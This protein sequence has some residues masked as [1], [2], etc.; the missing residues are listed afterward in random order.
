M[1][2]DSLKALNAVEIL[3]S[4]QVIVSSLEMLKIH[5]ALN[6]YGWLSWRV[7]RLSHPVFA[8]L[9]KKLRFDVLLKYPNVLGLIVFKILGGAF[10]IVLIFLNMSTLIPLLIIVTINLLMI[11]RNAQSNDGSDQMASIILIALSLA[12]IVN[13][14]FSRSATLVF[15]AAQ[16]SLAYGTSGFLKLPKIG[17]HDGSYATDIL[18]TSSFGNKKLL[19][20]FQKNRFIATTLGRA[21]VFGDCCIAFAFLMPPSISI[22]L[23]V[24][25]I[26]L[27]LGI[28][29]VMGL[30]TFLWSFVATYPAI[31]WVSVLINK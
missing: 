28:G 20:L 18:K 9:S 25:G 4:I 15:I 8:T 27:H 14:N 21:V 22:G 17:W 30:N 7:N 29:L 11:L 19:N 10:V 3:I 31:L 2:F 24:F 5:P 26:F 13:T 1:N 23:L 16:A 6:D 12:A